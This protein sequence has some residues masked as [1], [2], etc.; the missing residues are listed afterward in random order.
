M[1]KY[2][3]SSLKMELLGFKTDELYYLL[4]A[5]FYTICINEIILSDKNHFSEY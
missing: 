3:Y 2:Y 4:L 1:V 5:Y